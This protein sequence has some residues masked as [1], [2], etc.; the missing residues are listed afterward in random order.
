MAKF[1]S[2]YGCLG[3]TLSVILMNMNTWSEEVSVSRA[4]RTFPN[5]LPGKVVTTEKVFDTQT[6]RLF[7]RSNYESI[8]DAAGLFALEQ[9]EAGLVRAKDGALHRGLLEKLKATGDQDPVQVVVSLKHP[10][11]SPT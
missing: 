7:L 6:N 2:L 8:Q 5:A 9:A 11:A 10:R 3:A 1:R 4:T